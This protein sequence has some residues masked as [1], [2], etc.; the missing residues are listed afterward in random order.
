[1]AVQPSNSAWFA[2]APAAVS[3]L[4]LLWALS[5]V[6]SNLRALRRGTVRAGAYFGLALS[7]ALTAASAGLLAMIARVTDAGSVAT[8]V[9]AAVAGAIAGICLGEWRRRTGLRRR[10]KRFTKAVARG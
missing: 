6:G 1:M 10:L 3:V 8:L 9:A 2:T 4:V 7:G 5:L